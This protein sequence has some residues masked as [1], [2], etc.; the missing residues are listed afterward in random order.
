MAQQFISQPPLTVDWLSPVQHT[1]PQ[2]P[3]N[4]L[5]PTW[6]GYGHLGGLG[7]CAGAWHSG[8]G[9][10]GCVTCGGGNVLTDALAGLGRAHMRRA[11]LGSLSDEELAWRMPRWLQLTL[12]VVRLA[13]GAAGA[14]HGYKRHGDSVWGGIG[15]FFLGSLF[16]P[17]S[18]PVAFAQ[19]F[20]KRK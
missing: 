6:K 20:G 4:L 5:R 3:Q 7:D 19:G 2:V 17:I 16:W 10:C 18:I 8:Q 14:Y 1:T 15:W 13:G 12:G 11:T 9:S